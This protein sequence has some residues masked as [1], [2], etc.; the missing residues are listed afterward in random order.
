VAAA[1]VPQLFLPQ[2]ADQFFNA[3]A[4]TDTGAGRT[5]TSDADDTETLVEAARA[6]LADG[7][8]YAGARA[9]AS[10][11]AGMPSPAEIAARVEKWGRPHPEM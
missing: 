9:L 7:P 8:E 11:I 2:G 5:V 1:G 3:A 10:E 6:L 4:V